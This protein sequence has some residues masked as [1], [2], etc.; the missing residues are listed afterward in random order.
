MGYCCFVHSSARNLAFLAINFPDLSLRTTWLRLRPA[1]SIKFRPYYD[2][3]R[4]A[5]SC[6]NLLFS[7]QIEFRPWPSDTGYTSSQQFFVI[8]GLAGLN[9]LRVELFNTFSHIL[10]LFFLHKCIH[11]FNHY[12]SVHV[13]IMH[14]DA[15]FL[16]H[17]ESKK[18]MLPCR[19]LQAIIG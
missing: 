19:N 12:T 3:L 13:K 16:E 1:S 11:S 10:T 18:L 4:C 6:K 7:T 2:I 17:V 5:T 14:I 9:Y 8:L 15:N